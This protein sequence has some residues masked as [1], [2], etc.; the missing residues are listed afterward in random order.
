MRQRTDSSL[1][2]LYSCFLYLLRRELETTLD[3]LGEHV[4][5]MAAISSAPLDNDAIGD[6]EESVH[7]SVAETDKD[8][9][10][11]NLLADQTK[12]EK[13][14]EYLKE[15]LERASIEH[16]RMTHALI[17]RLDAFRAGEDVRTSPAS[18]T[19]RRK[20]VSTSS[21]STTHESQ[22]IF[23]RIHLLSDMLSKQVYTVC[24]NKTCQYK[25]FVYTV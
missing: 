5:N 13:R 19:A 25:C 12:L 7:E 1:S 6:E 20:S 3:N 24:L 15:L 23:S 22:P 17:E 8:Q 11:A 9:V 2:V 10:L 18:A 4:R 16:S 21:L 14:Q